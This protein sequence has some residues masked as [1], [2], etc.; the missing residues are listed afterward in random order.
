MNLLSLTAIIVAIALAVLILEQLSRH[1]RTPFNAW[2]VAAGFVGSEIALWFVDDLGIRW[3]HIQALI[4][5]LFVPILI[6]QTIIRLDIHLKW[7]DI[8]LMLIL[9]IPIALLSGT[10][11]GF[12]LYWL[13]GHPTGF[14][15]QSAL[16]AGFLL[17]STSP[18]A[19]GLILKDNHAPERLSNVMLMEGLFNGLIAIMLFFSIRDMPAN[20]SLHNLPQLSSHLLYNSVAGVAIG[21][22]LSTLLRPLLQLTPAGFRHALI[23]L[24]AC[25]LSHY[26]A[27][28]WAAS[29]IAALATTALL[30]LHAMQKHDQVADIQL[31][32]HIWAYKRYLA[33]S[34]LHIL[35][36]ISL[37]LAMFNER[38][39]AMLMGIFATLVVRAIISYLLL[40]A[41]RQWLNLQ[42]IPP[43]YRTV[44]WLGGSMRG[45]T[46][47]ALALSLP[48]SLEGWWTIQAI[49]YGT[50]LFSVSVQQGSLAYFV[51]R[52]Q[53]L[54]NNK[55][56]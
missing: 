11:I 53:R 6:F 35:M 22:G 10:G 44:L 18:T 17:A 15:L 19:M 23:L 40:P 28:S 26:L 47:I 16:I 1:T 24:A 50:V 42:A 48:T 54:T 20:L 34:S 56:Q 8:G 5:Y 46:T 38:W 45:G 13:I 41:L 31:T 12:L 55:I 14:P 9:T 49:A 27:I 36:G 52:A 2:L 43:H 33:S 25:F 3:Q 37:T 39:L 7:Q 4:L 32:Q 51:Q 29:S 21:W 30:L